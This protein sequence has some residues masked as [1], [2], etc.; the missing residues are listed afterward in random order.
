L[1][2]FFHE[3]N[4]SSG[5]LAQAVKQFGIGQTPV[6]IQ[7]TVDL[8]QENALRVDERVAITKNP[9]E[10]LDGPQRA[11]NAG[12]DARETNRPAFETLRK[13]QHVD[14]IFEHAR[15]AAVVFRRDDVQSGGLQNTV[16][17]RLKR[18]GKKSGPTLQ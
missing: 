11:P 17:E 10:L 7:Q 6:C 2:Q 5:L 9:L 1:F 8:R 18:L 13:F 3:I 4:E 16:S 15:N 12:R 14:E